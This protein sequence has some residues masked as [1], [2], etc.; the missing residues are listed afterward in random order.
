MEENL[1]VNVILK[2]LRE[3]RTENNQRWEE[4]DKRWEQ[5]EK[6]WEENDKRWKQNEKRW[7][8]ND[9]R[10]EQNDK[11][12]KENDKCWG[13]I[14]QRVTLL[15]EE[16]KEQSENTKRNVLKALEDMQVSITR[17]FEKLEKKFEIKL[18]KIEAALMD[19]EIEHKEF[20]EQL[21]A[22]QSRIKM[23]NVRID[24]LET[25]KDSFELGDISMV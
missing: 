8:E 22:C 13:Q 7:E 2:E 10:W 24:Q 12:W 25:W 5:N 1:T 19:N 23:Q 6:R 15:E 20:K 9:R 4:N 16:Q 18:D 11:R 21:A 3:F 14:N 17:Q